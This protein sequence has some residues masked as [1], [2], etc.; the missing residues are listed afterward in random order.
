MNS[1]TQFSV[2]P[3]WLKLLDDKS[4][5]ELADMLKREQTRR[6]IEK[7]D[8]LYDRFDPRHPS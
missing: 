7:A 8:K 2:T 1:G 6:I 5:D 4:I 3:D